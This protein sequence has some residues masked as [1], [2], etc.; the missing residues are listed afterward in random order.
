M[1]MAPNRQWLAIGVRG[2]APYRFEVDA[3]AYVGPRGRAALRLSPEYDI[4]LTQKLCLQPAVEANFY[5][6]DDKERAVGSGKI[7]VSSPV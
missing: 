5:G 6:T 3:T 7:R 2:T 4:L 1:T